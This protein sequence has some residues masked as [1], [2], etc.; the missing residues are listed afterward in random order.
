L[1]THIDRLQPP[2]SSA[3]PWHGGKGGGIGG[4]ITAKRGIGKY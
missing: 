1:N 4:K 2:A 3:N